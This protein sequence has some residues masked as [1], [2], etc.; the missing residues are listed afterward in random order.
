MMYSPPPAKKKT[1]VYWNENNRIW[2]YTSKLYFYIELW[3][4]G[5][6]YWNNWFFS[7]RSEISWLR[8][9]QKFIAFFLL[10]ILIMHHFK[11][12]NGILVLKIIALVSMKSLDYR[13]MPAFFN[14]IPSISNQFRHRGHVPKIIPTSIS[15]SGNKLHRG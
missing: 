10:L 4:R 7:K 8:T 9:F 6:I 3:G 12:K 15:A 1:F 2:N 11:D 5:S 14:H 13:K